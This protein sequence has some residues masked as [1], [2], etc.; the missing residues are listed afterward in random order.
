M[1]SRYALL[2]ALFVVTAAC[3]RLADRGT[4][5]NKKSQDQNPNNDPPV[6]Q[7][8]RGQLSAGSGSAL[9]SNLRLALLWYPGLHGTRDDD[10]GQP[11]DQGGCTLASPR[12]YSA[13]E[14]P[15][16]Y[17]ATGEFDLKILAPPS[18][19]VQSSE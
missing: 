7:Y 16:Q 8:Y 15:F 2:A 9:P 19:D 6:L 11:T 18:A 3:D 5:L 17:S 4:S 12:A 1:H 14:I 13:V 10:A